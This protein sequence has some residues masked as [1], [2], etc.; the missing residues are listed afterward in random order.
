MALGFNM[1]FIAIAATVYILLINRIPNIA[2]VEDSPLKRI[3]KTVFL[4]K[5]S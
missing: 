3:V 2:E 4:G 1:Y 5:S